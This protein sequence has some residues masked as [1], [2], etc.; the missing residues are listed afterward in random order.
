MTAEQKHPWSS[1]M[2]EMSQPQ[3]L[4]DLCLCPVLHQLRIKM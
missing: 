2:Q 4:R 1:L 3:L